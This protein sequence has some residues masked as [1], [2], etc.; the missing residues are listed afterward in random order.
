MYNT[1]LK[2]IF[3]DKKQLYTS[4]GVG[5]GILGDTHCQ[6]VEECNDSVA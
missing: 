2:N 6:L 1:A 5:H 4:T 3:P